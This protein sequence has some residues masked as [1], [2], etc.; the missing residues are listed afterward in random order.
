MNRNRRKLLTVCALILALCLSLT[1]CAESEGASPPGVK[2]TPTESGWD[3]VV[4]LLY[5]AK[6]LGSADEL[7]ALSI[8]ELCTVDDELYALITR[9]DTARDTGEIY[10]VSAGGE[11]KNVCSDKAGQTNACAICVGDGALWLVQEIS[12]GEETEYEL[13]KLEK[14]IIT[15]VAELELEARMEPT[16]LSVV[17]GSVYV[18]LTDGRTNT[19]V[20]YDLEGEKEYELDIGEGFELAGDGENLYIGKHGKPGSNLSLNRFNPDRREL[21]EIESFSGSFLLS[22]AGGR[23]YIVDE[24]SAYEYDT[25]SGEL[26]RMF[27]WTSEGMSGRGTALCPNTD[28][29]FYASEGKRLKYLRPYVGK[30][31]QQ[32]TIA[33]TYS[34]SEYTEAAAEFNETSTA[35]ELVIKNYSNY[36][37][38]MK[39]LAEEIAAGEIPDLVVMSGFSPELL[40]SGVMLDLMTY[41]ENDEE[42]STND[43]LAGPLGAMQTGSGELYAISP[44]FR[45]VTL[46]SWSDAVQGR[47]F[48]GIADALDWLGAPEEAFGGGVT[49]DDFLKYAFCCDESGSYTLEDLT[50]ILEYAA[51]MPEEYTN[52]GLE[53]IN[54][55]TGKQK[56]QLSVFD[57]IYI[58]EGAASFPTP[59]DNTKVYGL[60]FSGGTGVADVTG[61]GS[62]AIP[63]DAENPDGAWAFIKE[64]IKGSEGG[65]PLLK[66]RYEEQKSEYIER[67]E[68]WDKDFDFDAEL[69][70]E[71]S[72]YLMN[73][74]SGVYDSEGNSEILSIVQDD[75]AAYF[76]GTKTAEECA[77]IIK[78]RIDLYLAEQYG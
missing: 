71:L 26:S 66:S 72:D 6:T 77:K 49:R 1:G 75:A 24:T 40:D 56:F 78:S 55:R 64:C 43:L 17:G 74:L 52:D 34:G 47:D 69:I 18:G 54:I 28:G 33:V 4:T 37:A 62:L 44:A 57:A 19:L 20:V 65:F 7:Q 53:R 35:Y 41:L 25:V 2:T 3:G 11:M 73:G 76:A 14:G 12:V 8:G 31:R 29:S 50:A 39:K 30:E 60:P 32:V 38:P 22:C 5:S 67:V 59:V 58:L 68:A 23:V 46:L 13:C 70:L 9:H 27:D 48:T 51:R 42:V 63:A 21:E 10:L 15:R 16:A 36:R 45:D 61:Y